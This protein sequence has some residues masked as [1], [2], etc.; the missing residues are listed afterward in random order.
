MIR[1]ALVLL[2]LQ[3]TA[4]AEKH[5]P[6]AV[7]QTAS[8]V[9]FTISLKSAGSVFQQGEIIPLEL[10]FTASTKSRYSAAVRNYDRSGR[11]GI[12]Y[13]CV[14]PEAPDPLESYFK[15]GGFFG[16]GLGSSH[17]LD[18]TPFTAEAELNEW[19]T[20]RAGHY[21]VFAVSYRVSHVPDARDDTPYGRVGEMLRSHA[22]E[23]DVRPAD[24][25]WQAEQLR[26]AMQALTATGS[27]P[28]E[29]RH[30]ARRLRFLNTQESTKELARLFWGLNQQP[31]GWD[32]MFGLFGSPHRQLAIDSMRA[33]LISPSHAI[34]S[35]YLS[36]LVNLQITAD[37]SWDAPPDLGNREDDARRFWDRRQAHT[38]E[39]MTAEIQA[40][41]KALSR[42]S[43]RARALSLNGV[44]MA[45]GSDPATSEKIR[46][47]L[48][49]SWSDL[50]RE[51]QQELIQWRW[52][53]IAGPEMLPVLRRLVAEPPPQARTMDG[54]ARDEALK[55]LYELDRAA[56]RE[57]ILHDLGAG[58]E[59][60]LSVIQLLSKEELNAP[61]SRAVERIR[62]Y[63]A[64]DLDYQLL[65]KYA[66][67]SA[68]A[69]TK[70]EFEKH[71]G[72]WACAP[73]SAMLRYFLRV[74]PEYGAAQ[75]NAALEARKSTG[76]YRSL[77]QDL[78][79]ALPKV[80]QTA[81][82]ALADSDPEVVMDA[83]R[84]LER[85]GTAD[86]EP[87]LWARLRR[88]HEEWK[89]REDQLRS[90]PD[91]QSAGSRGVALE[92]SLTFAIARGVNWIC[93]PDKLAQLDALVL[94][95]PQHSQIDGWIKQ[96]KDGSALI[97]PT[98][99]P[100]DQPRFSVFQYE[101][102]TEDQFRTKM[103]Q[104]PSGMRLRWQFW[105]PGQISPP[106][107]ITKQDAAYDRVYAAAAQHGVA[108]EKVNHP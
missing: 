48:V 90:T 100:E 52:P 22:L 68:L 38:R 40:V 28:E 76:C 11:L 81:I 45:G 83:A 18:A 29:L 88:F 89:G 72:G 16:G 75:V 13:Y 85:W 15:Y 86:A 44:L 47:Q 62:D 5:D 106:V 20:L 58:G 3:Y 25:A 71:L 33:E 92:Q 2:V 8:D 105:Q 56:G 1:A 10:S 96:W 102:L 87:A 43:G 7:A 27:S 51:T 103:A 65:D 74:S 37:H 84:A 64:N 107:S 39:L 80:Q 32:L 42:K 9:R 59:P 26:T 63:K 98:W 77:L 93:P 50:P 79:S 4:G 91:Y 46:P 34:T 101:S 70:A 55:H 57:A 104:L 73:Q 54:M 19:R 53:L 21:R 99:F 66:D 23:I 95:K 36:T 6:C 108:I 24:P 35:E 60:S 30:A 69:A 49:A 67:G 78:G 61:V 94:T 82:D 97:N 31:A 41:L 14:E 17:E 12:E